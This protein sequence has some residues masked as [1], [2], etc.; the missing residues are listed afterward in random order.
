MGVSISIS[1]GEHWETSIAHNNRQFDEGDWQAEFHKHIDR[2]RVKDN[3]IIKAEP[4][5][6]AY[7]QIFGKAVA[8]YNSRQKRE[9]R[10]IADYFEKVKADKNLMLQQEIVVQFGDMWDYEDGTLSRDWAKMA[11]ERYVSDFGSRNPNLY[12]YNA[13]IHMDE[14]TPHLHLNFIPMATG[15]KKGVEVQPSLSK[16][17]INQGAPVRGREQLKAWFDQEWDILEGYLKEIGLERKLVGTNDYKDIH[18]YKR[19]MEPIN[20]ERAD[21]LAEV[22][23]IKAQIDDLRE[24]KAEVQEVGQ[25]A[26]KARFSDDMVIPREDF[27]VMKAQ[28]QAYVAEMQ[29]IQALKA[30][31]REK[32]TEIDAL[33]GDLRA[34]EARLSAWSDELM[35]Q[36]LAQVSWEDYEDLR[37]ENEALKKENQGL[38][39]HIKALEGSLSE[40]KG[41]LDQLYQNGLN[42]LRGAL[43]WI[44]DMAMAVKGF[45]EPG[46]PSY[47]QDISEETEDII[48]A[49]ADLS[50]DKLREWNADDLADNVADY[51]GLSDEIDD[52]AEDIHR[53]Y[54]KSL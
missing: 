45:L 6:E 2:E 36:E 8:A 5:R 7:E 12:I 32:S 31:I 20:Q 24:I 26:R 22:D 19:A 13:V 35:D 48:L 23:A 33:E 3:L 1:R 27:E 25:T 10:K 16:A 38:K 9:D 47:I 54:G 29:E 46:S 41:K 34:K 30:E 18:E 51:Y 28:S 50:E 42:G 49:I 15:Y 37:R 52:K 43:N 21:K 40:F 39:S 14:T 11:L 17:L 4:I 53:H 44:S